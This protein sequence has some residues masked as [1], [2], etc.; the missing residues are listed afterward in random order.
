ME[1]VPP[2]GQKGTTRDAQGRRWDNHTNQDEVELYRR[3]WGQGWLQDTCDRLEEGWI[4]N[5]F[6]EHVRVLSLIHI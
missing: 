6:N 1:V 5:A 4:V 2:P 3:Y